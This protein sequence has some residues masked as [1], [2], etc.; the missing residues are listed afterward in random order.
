M[1]FAAAI[2]VVVPT[3]LS[4]GCERPQPIYDD[5]IGVQAEPAEVGSLAGTFALKTIN[6][7]LVH[8]PF[9]TEEEV[10]GGGVNFRLVTREWDEEQQ[11]YL[12]RSTLC[13]G[14]NFEVMGVTTT[15]PGPTYREVP[16]ST[17]EWVKVEHDLGTY[18][19]G[20]HLQLWAI[21][22]EDPFEDA[23]PA[24]REEAES[25]AF[26]DR[27]FDLEEDG[28]PGLT[29]FVSGLV[30]GEIYAAQR[31]RVDLEGVIQGA[32]YA[33][34]LAKNTFESVTLGNNND[35]LDASEQGSAEPYPDPK[36]SWFQE[37]RIPA[38]TS[39]DD[40]A[41]ME[42]TGELSRPRPF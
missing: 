31:K 6:A 33:V 41:R 19:S 18:E 40:V 42:D 17:E 20:G 11:L 14:Y 25:A 10:I 26:R 39:C 35:L 7:T 32:D 5:D 36:E 24:D 23:F 4:F 30:E 1:R 16:E 27:I 28:S 3:L 12:Q 9:Q 29:L 22:L 15:V 34:G 13:G 38:D 21:D 2:T 8:V 37:V